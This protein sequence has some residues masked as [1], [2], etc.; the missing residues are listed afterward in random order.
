MPRVPAL[1][2]SQVQNLK[3]SNHLGS[4]ASDGTL[5]VWG[6]F[7]ETWGSG[8]GRPL[9]GTY[10]R[11]SQNMDHRTDVMYCSRCDDDRPS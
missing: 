5:P 2:F 1:Y 4:E 3:R 7:A 8:L 9:D 11:S 6:N 10:S